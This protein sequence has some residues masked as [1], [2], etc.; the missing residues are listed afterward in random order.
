MNPA[1]RLLGTIRVVHRRSAA[2]TAWLVV[3]TTIGVAVKATR[4]GSR[5]GRAVA[6]TL[7]PLTGVVAAPPVLPERYQPVH[8]L[9]GLADAGHDQRLAAGQV[10]RRSMP[11]AAAQILDQLD[12]TELIR[13]RVDLNALMT[14]VDINAVVARADLDAIAARL[15]LIGLARYVAA[16]L[17]LPEA[18]SLT[19]EA[20]RETRIQGVEADQA[21]AE[22]VD[23]VFRPRQRP[24]TD[25][26]GEL[27][28]PEE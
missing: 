17:Y 11:I 12:L 23:R 21:I 3:D 13:D 25:D 20:V 4:T 9:R 1:V 16:G 6:R 8:L 27:S 14:D 24:D 5:V 2:D 7:R 15:D 19:T 26:P 10:L 18:G 22:W 28:E